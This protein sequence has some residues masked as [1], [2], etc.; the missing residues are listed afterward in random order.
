MPTWLVLDKAARCFDIRLDYLEALVNVGSLLLRRAAR[1][2]LVDGVRQILLDDLERIVAEPNRSESGV[3]TDFGDG[4][5]NPRGEWFR[6]VRWAQEG[7]LK[8]CFSRQSLIRYRHER[9][10]LLENMEFEGFLVPVH[11]GNGKWKE[12]W[13]FKQTQLE[14]LSEILAVGRAVDPLRG[15][16]VSYRECKDEFGLSRNTLDNWHAD[17]IPDLENQKLGRWFEWRPVERKRS[18]RSSILV[19]RAFVVFS[20][21]QI[22][23]ALEAQRKRAIAA[24]GPK[25]ELTDR[26][27][28]ARFTGIFRDGDLYRWRKYCHLI[29]RP[30]VARQ[31]PDG[32]WLNRLQDLRTIADKL[33]EHED[34][35]E[36]VRNGTIYIPLRAFIRVCG[37]EHE[38]SAGNYCQGDS[39]LSHSALGRPIERIQVN[40]AEKYIRR[41]RH[42]ENYWYLKEDAEKIREW[43]AA[44][45]EKKEKTI[46]F[47]LALL[48]QG[49]ILHEKVCALGNEV[50]LSL[51][52][53]KKA[54]Q[55]HNEHVERG[56]RETQILS[57]K[58]AFRG[59]TVWFL[60]GQ[61]PKQFVEDPKMPQDFARSCAPGSQ[62][63]VSDL[64]S[65][66]N[67]NGLIATHGSK[68]AELGAKAS[69]ALLRIYTNGIADERF[70]TAVLLLSNSDLTAN[71]KLIKIDALIPFPPTASAEQLAEMLGVTKQAVLKTEWWLQNRKGEK[72]SEVGRRREG[73]RNRASNYETPSPADE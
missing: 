55:T 17:G 34:K 64:L 8:L 49:P 39:P 10:P 46:R 54:R 45:K 56:K 9:T 12:V 1:S 71:E 31:L 73:H 26:E 21:E 69:H 67:A 4:L 14:R 53:L 59:P 68:E 58:I 33:L 6:T 29:C 11:V 15:P 27:A 28:M 36:I 19:A 32:T 52:V 5:E 2:Q 3:F 50:G 24:Q 66:P 35:G 41:N 20:P 48:S 72:E 18:G 44:R 62:L 43:R 40:A 7:H 57:Q 47:L 13:V 61:D 70:E 65:H 30:L 63:Q 37:Y 22:E 16:G 42:P 60:E 25:T 51:H 23:D 38:Q